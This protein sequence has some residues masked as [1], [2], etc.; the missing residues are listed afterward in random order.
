MKH[1]TRKG[2]L[3]INGVV[4]FAIVLFVAAIISS[5]LFTQLYSLEGLGPC[6][7]PFKGVASVLADMTGANMC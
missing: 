2:S 5:I 3:P 1:Q 4:S 7:G 6:V